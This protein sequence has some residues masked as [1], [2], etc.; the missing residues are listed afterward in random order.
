MVVQRLLVSREPDLAEF[1]AILWNPVCLKLALKEQGRVPGEEGQ[2]AASESLATLLIHKGLNLTGFRDNTGSDSEWKFQHS[3]S[4][5]EHE[6]P[7]KVRISR[8]ANPV[9][10]TLTQAAQSQCNYGKAGQE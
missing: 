10:V 2:W 8:M 3:C 7:G 5:D 6:I 1:L 9:N 4:T